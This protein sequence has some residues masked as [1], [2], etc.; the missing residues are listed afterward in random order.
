[1]INN[2]PTIYEVVTG[3]SRKPLKEKTSNSSSKRKTSS[4]MVSS[5]SIFML[6]LTY[7][8]IPNNNSLGRVRVSPRLR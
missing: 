7:M 6:P 2:L 4:R 8:Q 5:S 1:M 3:A